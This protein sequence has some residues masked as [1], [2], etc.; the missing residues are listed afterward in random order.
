MQQEITYA[1][2]TIERTQ[3]EQDLVLVYLDYP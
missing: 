1:G 3:E 2:F